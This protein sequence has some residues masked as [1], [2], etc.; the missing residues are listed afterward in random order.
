MVAHTL[1]FHDFG[2]CL[3]DFTILQTV[4]SPMEEHS[5]GP[6]YD[7]NCALYWFRAQTILDKTLL[8]VSNFVLIN[9]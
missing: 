4:K 2:V 1:S 7:R 9:S 5:D 6:I 3:E 8:S